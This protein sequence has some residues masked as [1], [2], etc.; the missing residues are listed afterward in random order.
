M[1]CNHP[2]CKKQIGHKVKLTQKDIN[3]NI[4]NKEIIGNENIENENIIDNDKLSKN[5]AQIY[6]ENQLKKDIFGNEKGLN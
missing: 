2:Q 3:M 1:F 6:Q 4:S 5:L